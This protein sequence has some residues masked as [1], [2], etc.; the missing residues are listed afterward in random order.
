IGKTTIPLQAP[1]LS[2]A[3]SP[4]SPAFNT[5]ISITPH[6]KPFTFTHFLNTIPYHLRHTQQIHKSINQ[7]PFLL[8]NPLPPHSNK[9]P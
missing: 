2:A 4:H 1:Y 7:K 6:S 8:P 3:S 5:I 9:K